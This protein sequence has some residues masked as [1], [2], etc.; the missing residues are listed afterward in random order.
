MK[1]K[2]FGINFEFEIV[3]DEGGRIKEERSAY[4]YQQLEIGEWPLAEIKNDKEL[5][6][7]VDSTEERKC[8]I[9]LILQTFHELR[10]IKQNNDIQDN[11]ILNEETLKMT[12]ELIINDSFI[13]FRNRFNYEQS[14]IEIDAMRASLQET[15]LFFKTMGANI[16][17]DEVVS[18][19]KEKELSYLNY[20]LSEIGNSYDSVM[21]YFNH[22]YGKI[23]DIKGITDIIQSLPEDK[24]EILYSQCQNLI[25]CYNLET[26][27]EKKMDLLQKMSLIMTPELREKYPLIEF[28][29]INK[30]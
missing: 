26:D 10:H 17:P 20:N 14:I 1:K 23:I 9:E 6:I 15:I 27:V 21:T 16:T 22:I 8:F 3:Y 13:G 7:E 5:G 19:M 4:G 28:Q 18:V 11:P 25:N 30:R 24:K 12:R 29:V 2:E